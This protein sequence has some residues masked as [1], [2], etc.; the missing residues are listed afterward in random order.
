MALRTG[1][2]L[3]SIKRFGESLGRGG[4]NFAQSLFLPDEAR[5]A[6]LEHLAGI[7]AAKEAALK[8]LGM[9]AGQWLLVHVT[10]DSSGAPRLEVDL[11]AIQSKELSVSIS[12]DGDYALAIVIAIL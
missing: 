11:S 4:A 7:F 10:H 9:S 12:H 6:S 8:A 3:V 2:D 1:T 5:G